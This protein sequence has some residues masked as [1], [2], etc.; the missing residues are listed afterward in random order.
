MG[1]NL[2]IAL[3][4]DGAQREERWSARYATVL[5]DDPGSAVLTLTSVG[6]L[7]RSVMPGE[8]EP[9]EIGLWKGGEGKV[10]VLRLPRD[11]HALLLT[12][13]IEGE[14]Y[15]TLDGRSDEGNTFE[16]YLSG[17]HPVKHPCPPEWAK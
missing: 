3:L 9:T 16:L 5:A 6:L 7:R 1:P 14:T 17:V 4:M 2:V 11:H 8:L 15:F 12:V 10:K 13:S